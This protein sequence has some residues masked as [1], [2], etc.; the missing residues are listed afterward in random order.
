MAW[1][2]RAVP[3]PRA[4]WPRGPPAATRHDHTSVAVWQAAATS[5]PTKCVSSVAE[6]ASRRGEV[7]SAYYPFLLEPVQHYTRWIMA[8]LARR[9]STAVC[10]MY[11]SRRPVRETYSNKPSDTD[12]QDGPGG[13]RTAYPNPL[14]P[15]RSAALSRDGA[16]RRRA[17]ASLRAGRSRRFQQ[18]RKSNY[19]SYSRRACGHSPRGT[20]RGSS[21]R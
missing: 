17:C 20:V 9:R 6:A 21:G 5:A 19:S 18:K 10:T 8:R 7:R 12:A 4:A 3:I 13:G 16:D 2:R 1:T 11:F 15:S 14:S